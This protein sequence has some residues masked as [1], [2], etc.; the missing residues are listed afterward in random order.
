MLVTHISVTSEASTV[1]KGT[2]HP[3]YVNTSIVS[4]IAALHDG[5]CARPLAQISHICKC[6]RGIKSTVRGFSQQRTTCFLSTHVNL[7]NINDACSAGWALCEAFGAQLAHLQVLARQK[8]DCPWVF[9][10]HNA[11]RVLGVAA[12]ACRAVSTQKER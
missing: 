12:A 5:P 11:Q 8:H 6:L 3:L 7:E 10:A 4:S 1:L 9:P 2:N